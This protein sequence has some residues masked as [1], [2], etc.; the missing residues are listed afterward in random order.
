M[1]RFIIG[2]VASLV[3]TAALPALGAD[4]SRAM[5][6]W[7]GPSQAVIDFSLQRGVDRLFL[8]A[9]PGF[10]DDATFDSFLANAHQAGL[11]VYALAGD[12]SWAKRS[13]PFMQ[14]VDEVVDHGGFDGLAPDVEPY[15]LPDWNNKK[16]RPKVISSYLSALD[17]ARSRAGGLPLVPAVP[18]WWDEP[19]FAVKGSLLI[20]EVL[21]RVDGIAVMAYRDTAQGPNGIIALAGYEVAAATAAGKSAIIGVETAPNSL[22]YVTFFEEGNAVMETVLAEV[23][24][25]WVSSAGYWGNAIHHYGS[26]VSL[27]P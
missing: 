16:R 19:E 23:S 18:F 13:R 6:V 1:R 14:W 11:E 2:V 24:A 27:A 25:H 21:N 9:P 3:M 17:G 12:P 26:Y 20:D 5:W 22:D 8:N 15:A 7:D 10:S 4:P